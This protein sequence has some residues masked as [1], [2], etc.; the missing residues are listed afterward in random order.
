MVCAGSDLCAFESKQGIT[1]S[2]SCSSSEQHTVDWS[3]LAY[4]WAVLGRYVVQVAA[5]MVPLW[6]SCN[7]TALPTAEQQRD[8]F[9]V[10]QT[11]P[12]VAC[13][14]TFC[15]TLRAALE[16]GH[17]LLS[18]PTFCTW[19]HLKLAWCRSFHPEPGVLGSFDASRKW[20]SVDELDQ[21]QSTY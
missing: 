8:S 18:P 16:T 3:M 9:S 14:Q 21:K 10:Q 5:F 6:Q 17:F 20:L 11:G 13:K 15:G 4:V 1:W 12:L 7:R 2:H 19:L